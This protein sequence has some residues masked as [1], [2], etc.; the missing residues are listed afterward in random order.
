MSIIKDPEVYE[1]FDKVVLVHGV[2]HVSELAYSDYIRGELPANEYFGDVA[3]AKLIYYP[4]VTR[5]PYVNRGRITQIIE[6]GALANDIGL[7]PLSLEN[8]RVMLCGSPEMIADARTMLTGLNFVEG[9]QG[10]AG[11]YVIEKA[12][13]EK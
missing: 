8:D 4:T 12:F 6:S 10:E 5:E 1:R 3:R 2:R 7:P 13:V 11:H 9:N